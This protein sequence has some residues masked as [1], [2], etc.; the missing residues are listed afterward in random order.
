MDNEALF[1]FDKWFDDWDTR[2]IRLDKNTREI[3]KLEKEYDEKSKT[4]LQKAIED[5]VDFKAIYGGNT[6]KTRKQ[7]VDEQLADLLN[8]K[9][10]L[11]L[12]KS[13]DNRRISFIKKM[14]TLHLELMKYQ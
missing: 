8:K 1:E 10:E 13:D 11:E 4:I 9:E 3:I 2:I 5:K 12:Q 6:E 14:I 7:Y